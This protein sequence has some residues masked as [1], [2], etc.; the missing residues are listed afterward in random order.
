MGEVEGRT[1]RGGHGF[2]EWNLDLSGGGLID[3]E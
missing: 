1:R 2:L 3:G